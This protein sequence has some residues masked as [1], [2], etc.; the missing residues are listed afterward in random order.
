MLEKG[1]FCWTQI[2]TTVL[3]SYPGPSPNKPP[4]V[5]RVIST[6]TA[7]LSNVAAHSGLHL[8]QGMGGVGGFSTLPEMA[9]ALYSA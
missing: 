3:P 4:L 5:S 1:F 8:R 7:P 9:M 2:N 6:N